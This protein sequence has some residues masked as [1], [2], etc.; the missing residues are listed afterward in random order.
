M[1][2]KGQF[3][4]ISG[5]KKRIMHVEQNADQLWCIL[6]R[7]LCVIF[8]HFET[9]E[10]VKHAFEKIKVP[11]AKPKSKQIEKCKYFT[12]LDSGNK[13]TDDWY[14][15]LRQCQG[16]FINILDCGYMLNDALNYGYTFLLDFNTNVVYFTFTEY[17]GKCKTIQTLTLHQILSLENAP[18][19]TYNEIVDEFKKQYCINNEKIIQINDE[20]TKIKNIIIHAKTQNSIN[21]EEKATSLLDNAEWELKKIKMYNNNLNYRMEQLLIK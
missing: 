12:D 15:L 2:T 3:G 9:I 13:S 19:K 8:K 10:N 4:F 7:E 18:I 17:N 14:C 6:I 20:I 11:T 16:S 5:K 21:I 1:G